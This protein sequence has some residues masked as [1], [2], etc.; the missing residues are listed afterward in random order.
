MDYKVFEG[1]CWLGVFVEV[2][3]GLCKVLGV[4]WG[5][6]CGDWD[7][8][9]VCLVNWVLDVVLMWFEMCMFLEKVVSYI[10]MFMFVML[11]L[12]MWVSGL[13]DLFLMCK[14][15]WLGEGMLDCVMD[16]CI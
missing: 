13:F 16:V 7:I 10:L 15:Y 9:K 8:V 3:L 2:F 6:G 14:V 12:V 5:C 11:W 1:G 4:V